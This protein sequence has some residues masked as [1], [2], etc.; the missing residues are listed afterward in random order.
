[1]TVIGNITPLLIR[2]MNGNE[3]RS[4]FLTS[5][6]LLPLLA[7]I[8]PLLIRIMN[9]I[10]VVQ[11]PLYSVKR[12]LVQCQKRPSTVSKETYKERHQRC[13]KSFIQ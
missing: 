7:N 5:R 2:I 6:F 13:A 4:L 1:M 8:T 12:D 11:S 3:S 10:N 9:G